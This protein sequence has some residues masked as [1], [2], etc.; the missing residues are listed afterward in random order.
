MSSGA[1]AAPSSTYLRVRNVLELLWRHPCRLGGVSL[2]RSGLARSKPGGVQHV[3]QVGHVRA[4][5]VEEELELDGG[6]PHEV[7]RAKTIRTF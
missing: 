7:M 1:P 4:R 5:S 6:L 3:P 2:R